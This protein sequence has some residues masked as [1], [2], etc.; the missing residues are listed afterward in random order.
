MTKKSNVESRKSKNQ[1]SK[2]RVIFNIW[3]FVGGRGVWV[4]DMDLQ[5][6]GFGDVEHE[7]ST[8]Y[9][10]V[11]LTFLAKEMEG[12]EDDG[13]VGQVPQQQRMPKVCQPAIAPEAKAL[14]FLQPS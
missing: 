4:W 10:Y 2:W 7:A 8:T 9:W 5:R 12:M 1:K 6:S 13:S 3:W 11:Q 14:R